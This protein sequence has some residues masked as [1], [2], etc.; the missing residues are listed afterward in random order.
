LQIMSVIHIIS[1]LWTSFF[2]V[3]L[4]AWMWTKRTRER[5]PLS[6]RLL[7]GIPVCIGS[8]LMLTDNVQLGWLEWRLIPK[9]M[10]LQILAVSLTT[11]GIALAIWARFYLGQNWSSAVSI[12]VGHQLIHTGPYRWVRH[13]I[14]SGIL[15]ALIG[16]VLERGKPAGLLAIALFWL[17]FWIKSSMEERFM[18]KTFGQDYEAYSRTTGALVPRLHISTQSRSTEA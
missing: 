5:V 4:L 18:R 7:Y 3:W 6:S 8:Y 12:K 10:L 14:Y 9:N 17:G 2:F 13:P 15:L 11:A 1:A 16:T